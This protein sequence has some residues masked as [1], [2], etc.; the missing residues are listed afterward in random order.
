M[1]RNEEKVC[2]TWLVCPSMMISHRAAV[3]DRIEDL[4]GVDVQDPPEVLFII[5]PIRLA[6]T[7]VSWTTDCMSLRVD[8]GASPDFT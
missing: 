5:V 8:C 6:Q 7:C 4:L 1:Y 3:K 2:N